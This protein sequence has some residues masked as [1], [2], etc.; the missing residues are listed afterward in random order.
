MGQYL[1]IGGGTNEDDEIAARLQAEY[2]HK[3]SEGQN[4]GLLNNNKQSLLNSEVAQMKA[5]NIQKNSQPSPLV[6]TF[7]RL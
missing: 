3:M 6:D 7:N 4:Q 2:N 5:L 1:S